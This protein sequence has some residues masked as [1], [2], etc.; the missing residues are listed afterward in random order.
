MRKGGEAER[1]ASFHPGEEEALGD[2]INVSNYLNGGC[3]EDRAR[4]F[5]VVPSD[6][7]RSNEHNLKRQEV[8]PDLQEALCHCAGDH[9]KEQTRIAQSGCGVSLL[10]DLLKPPGHGSGQPA[11]AAN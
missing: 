5:L 1:A 8:L 10:G 11:Q 6:R 2:L 9:S 7:T 3:K 4:L